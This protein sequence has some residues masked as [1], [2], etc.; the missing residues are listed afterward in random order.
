[1]QS[2]YHIDSDDDEEEVAPVNVPKSATGHIHQLDKLKTKTTG[3][4]GA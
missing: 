1:M 2:A 3:L 4:L